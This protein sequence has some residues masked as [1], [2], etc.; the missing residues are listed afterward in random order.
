VDGADPTKYL[1]GNAVYAFAARLTN[2]YAR[3]G[4]CAAFR[5]ME[6]GGLVQDLPLQRFL[7]D[8]GENVVTCPTE[9]AIT[10]RRR[11]ELMRLGFIALCHEKGTGRAVFFE[12]P[13]CH[14]TRLYLDSGRTL[15]DTDFAK[16]EVIFAVSRFSQYIRAIT[17]DK[18]GHSYSRRE[19]ERYLNEWLA[20]YV[21]L[22]DALELDVKARYP[23]AEGSISLVETP[24]LPG[25]YRAILTMRPN[26]QL[27][28]ESSIEQNVDRLDLRSQG[29][30]YGR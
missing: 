22:D 28:L 5:G 10:D 20:G 16:L 7:S 6:H 23:L 25:Q 15:A 29:N 11:E 27:Q 3:N 17:R 9:I 1:W 19:W 8:D 24:G 4:W 21:L 26:Y 18:W 2:A 13:S 30:Q 12:T 14:K